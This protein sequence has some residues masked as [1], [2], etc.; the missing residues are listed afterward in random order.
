M[1]WM[2]IYEYA[3]PGGA[4]TQVLLNHLDHGHHGNLSFQGKIL[5]VEMG[6]EPGT[7]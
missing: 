1:R 3:V 2:V 7:S 4:L 6:I 5:M